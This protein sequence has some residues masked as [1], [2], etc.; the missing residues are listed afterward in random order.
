VK[1]TEM[2]AEG[3]KYVRS[4]SRLVV[5]PTPDIRTAVA[6]PEVA[7]RGAKATA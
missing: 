3:M 1:E 2:L 6:R 7:S 4:A 5:S